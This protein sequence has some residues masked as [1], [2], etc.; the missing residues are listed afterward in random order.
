MFEYTFY[1]DLADS[2]D[3]PKAGITSRPLYK[4]DRLRA[5]IFGF[6]EGEEM[7]EHTAAVPAIVQIIEGE[8]AFTL[9]NETKEMKAGAWVLM[10]A[11]L[12]HRIVSLTPLKLMLYLLR[13]P[14]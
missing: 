3:I 5:V 6:A 9:E 13:T 1:E 11:H 2:I 10:D 14:K 12:P 7:S 8:C 4:S